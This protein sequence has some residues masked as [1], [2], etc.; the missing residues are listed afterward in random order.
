MSGIYRTHIQ[1]Q[2]KGNVKG[3]GFYV[4][5]QCDM[6]FTICAQRRRKLAHG[7]KTALL[8]AFDWQTG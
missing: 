1:T 2:N 7:S 8:Y 4:A 5:V 6:I 3:E